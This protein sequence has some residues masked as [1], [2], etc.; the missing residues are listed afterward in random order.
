MQELI[1]LSE[2]RPSKP[3]YRFGYF[4]PEQ[5]IDEIKN[6]I[7]KEYPE[8]IKRDISVDTYVNITVYT[9]NKGDDT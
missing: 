8:F 9:K 2:V 7:L 5:L 1:F 3:T 6:K 4:L